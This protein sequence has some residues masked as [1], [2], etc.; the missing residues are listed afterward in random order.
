MYG[1]KTK[2]LISCGVTAQLICGFVFA[3]IDCWFSDA[4]AH[5]IVDCGIII[6]FVKCLTTEFAL[7]WIRDEIYNVA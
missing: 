2:A 7:T 4:M 5:L 6:V 1:A 3:Q